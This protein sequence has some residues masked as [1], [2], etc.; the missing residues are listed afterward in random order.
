VKDGTGG[1]A[2][3]SGET[4]ETV[5]FERPQEW[6]EWLAAHHGSAA[7][8]MVGFRRKGSGLPGMTWPESV[9]EA[10]CHGWIDGVRRRLDDV[11]YVIRFT[12]RRPGS[13]WSNVNVRRFGELREA[14]RTRPAGEAAFAARRQDRSG[15]Y[16]YEAP[17]EAE[18][19]PPFEAEFRAAAGAWAFFGTQAP[20]YRRTAVHWVMSAKQQATRERRLR[21]LIEASARGERP[22]Q[23]SYG[24]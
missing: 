10:L 8:L 19:T 24:G 12:P 17:R 7:E 14:G 5:F 23:F 20:S 22:R 18:L 1:G 15:I 16:A 9:D 4:G 11:S 6:R 21:T 13:I 3:G 2:G